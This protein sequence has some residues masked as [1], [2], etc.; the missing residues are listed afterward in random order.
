LAALLDGLKG[1]TRGLRGL[2][3][4]IPDEVAGE[5]EVGGFVVLMVDPD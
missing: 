4:A 1:C 5:A 2:K 3:L